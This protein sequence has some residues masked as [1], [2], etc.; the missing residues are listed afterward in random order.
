MQTK[1][2]GRWWQTLVTPLALRDFEDLNF[3][4]WARDELV[5]QF[6]ELGDCRSMRDDPRVMAIGRWD[7]RGMFRLKL[8]EPPALAQQARG[9]VA[10]IR[11]D[12]SRPRGALMLVGVFMRNAHTYEL[13]LTRRMEELHRLAEPTRKREKAW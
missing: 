7:C 4:V 1:R 3:P 2:E 12:T 9:I 6:H 11:F 10:M 5:R 8:Q 13:T